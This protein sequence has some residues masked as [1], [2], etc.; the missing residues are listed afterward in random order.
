MSASLLEVRNLNLD[1]GA[2][3][4]LRDVSFSVAAG[5]ILGLVGASGSGKSMT[6]LSVLQL[7]PP[8]ARLRG[9]LQVCGHE[10][11]GMRAQNLTAMRGR[12]VGMVFQEP[13]TAL[14][15]VMRIGDQVAESLHLHGGAPA[16][17]LKARVLEAFEQVGL[18]GIAHL[19]RRYP[20]Q[21][22]GG[23]RQ[24]AAIAMALL[25]AP[26]LLIADEPTTALDV[27]T[28]QQVLE[29]LQT[30][31]R[32]RGMG[33]ILV[34][35]DMAVVAQV[36]DRIAVMQ[37][38]SIVEHGPTGTVL[39]SPQHAYTR[40]LL[41]A[42]APAPLRVPVA[43]QAAPLLQ[44]E[45][46][47][48]EY[49]LPRR[50]WRRAAR[51][52]AVDQVSLEVDAGETVG[53]VG[54]S[55]SGK[56]S[57]LRM[58]LALDRCQAGRVVLR[59]ESFS[60]ARGAALRPLRRT[61]QAVF[62]DPFGSFDPR[63]R[64]G[65]VIAE[66]FYLLDAPLARA[67]RARRVAQALEQV[68]LSAADARRLPHEFSGGQRQRIALARALVIEPALIVFDE[69]VSALDVLVRAQILALL[70]E[71]AAR[72]KIAYLFVSHDLNVVRAIADRVYVMQRGRIVEQGATA[73]VFAA[74]QHAY[75]RALLEATPR[76]PV[77]AAQ[78]A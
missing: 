28:Q 64:V 15:P 25:A 78:P 38:G 42:A 72:L 24:R 3:S 48:R 20:Y 33:M 35:H 44:V 27:I 61:V 22:S 9:S 14:N 63:W 23:Q 47:V 32:Q 12:D 53:L 58:V 18:Q 36:T 30:L 62:Q 5:E 16:G 70:A 54:E 29:L 74:P 75:T 59:G 26:P 73:T 51:L 57:L 34:S 69:A 41:A 7:L 39:H 40:A 65:R 60:A 67:E 1:I 55:G 8:Q 50:S 10:L 71:L 76:L 17:V 52:R 77:F 68:G 2:R 45:A 66:P 43:R 11:Q 19:E 49:L 21:L 4:I 6:A 13:L 37:A 31:V 46:V 56:S